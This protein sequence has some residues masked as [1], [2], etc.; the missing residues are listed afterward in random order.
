MTVRILTGIDQAEYTALLAQTHFQHKECFRFSPSAIEDTPL[1]GGTSEHFTLGAFSDADCLVGIM[2]FARDT[3]EKMRHKGLLFRMYV[4][5]EAAGQGIGR[6]LLGE[7][8]S[9]ARLLPGLEAVILTVIASNAPAR[10]LYASEGF[11]AFSLEPRALKT[12]DTYLDE[13]QMRLD[14]L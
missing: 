12:G 1:I 2:S 9:R 7:T 3:H 4:A 10:N 13:E 8:I 6:R 11:T 5:G 14:L